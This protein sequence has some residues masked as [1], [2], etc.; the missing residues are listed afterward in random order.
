MLQDTGRINAKLFK[1]RPDEALVYSRR[2]IEE[3]IADI[4]HHLRLFET[5]FELMGV[6]PYRVLYEDLAENPQQVV[7]G[8]GA[9]MGMPGLRVRTERVRLRRQ[10]NSVNETWRAR[11]LAG[12]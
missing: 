10:A 2:V 8:I 3:T 12:E 6:T 7:D 4:E 1:D 5:A 9:W 11:Y